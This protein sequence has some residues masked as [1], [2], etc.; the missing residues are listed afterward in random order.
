MG[1]PS[2]VHLF[3]SFGLFSGPEFV[4]WFGRN[5]FGE[6]CQFGRFSRLSSLAM[7]LSKTFA[8]AVGELTFDLVTTSTSMSSSLRRSSK[9]LYVCCSRRAM[10]MAP[11]KLSG[12]V[13]MSLCAIRSFP[14]PSMRVFTRTSPIM[15]FCKFWPGYASIAIRLIRSP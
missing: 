8:S 6:F 10:A 7:I 3:S 4:G 14:T 9:S 11:S 15:G 1:R 12:R 13:R 2:S 5:D